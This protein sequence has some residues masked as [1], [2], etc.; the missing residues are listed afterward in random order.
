MLKARKAL[1]QIYARALEKNVILMVLDEM[2]A[3][4]FPKE[5]Y[6]KYLNEAIK[7]GLIPRAG[8][9]EIDGK[10]MQ[11][12]DILKIQDILREIPDDEFLDDLYFYGVG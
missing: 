8:I 5:L 10:I 12:S 3:R 6:D 7:I 11:E 4:G 9:S 1:R 2:R